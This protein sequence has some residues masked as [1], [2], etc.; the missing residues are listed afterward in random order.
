[1]NFNHV[2]SLIFS[3]AHFSILGSRLAAPQMTRFRQ[4]LTVLDLVHLN[5]QE[6]TRLICEILNAS[7]TFANLFATRVYRQ[8]FQF[9]C[10]F[11][12]FFKPRAQLVIL[13]KSHN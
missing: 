1:M 8:H 9:H 12:R 10:D 4:V 5:Y 2:N 7:W 6:Y 11:I 13:A 3:C